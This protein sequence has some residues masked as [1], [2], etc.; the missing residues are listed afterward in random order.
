MIENEKNSYHFYLLNSI[1]LYNWNV[2]RTY[3]LHLLSLDYII[4]LVCTITS[5]YVNSLRG[6]LFTRIFIFT[7]AGVKCCV[8]AVKSR[9]DFISVLLYFTGPSV[10]MVLLAYMVFTVGK[11]KQTKHTHTSMVPIHLVLRIEYRSSRC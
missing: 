9:P 8:V 6:R 4:F 2:Y 1:S 7:T 11:G 3:F 5:Y 10:S